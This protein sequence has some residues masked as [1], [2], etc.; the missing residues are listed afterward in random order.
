MRRQDDEI[1]QTKNTHQLNIRLNRENFALLNQISKDVKQSPS[2]IGSQIISQWVEFYYYKICRGDVIFSKQVLKKI[3]GILDKS[4]IDSIS[5][6][7]A[8]HIIKEIKLQEGDVT[9]PVLSD[10]ILKWNKGNSLQ[11]NRIKQNNNHDDDY[12]D[13]FISKHNLGCNW[14]ELECKT[15]TRAFEMIGQHVDSSEYEEDMFC[16]KVI[17]RKD[18]Q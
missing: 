11:L 6:F 9:Y 7:T 5:K 17:N 15:Y 3:I 1:L 2:T 14:S 12:L 16:I 10:R 13:V 4:E 18:R 8:K